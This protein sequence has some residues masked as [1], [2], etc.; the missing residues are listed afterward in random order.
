VVEPH[1]TGHPAEVSRLIA[2]GETVLLDSGTTC[3]E[4][5]RLLHGRQESSAA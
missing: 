1:E 3:L 5:A 2:D 4:I